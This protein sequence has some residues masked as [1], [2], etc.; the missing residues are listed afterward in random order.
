M[1]FVLLTKE[2]RS[3]NIKGVDVLLLSLSHIECPNNIL[4]TLIVIRIVTWCCLPCFH[5]GS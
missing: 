2:T 5:I 3:Q 4:I 1:K